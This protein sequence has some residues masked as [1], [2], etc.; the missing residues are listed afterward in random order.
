[1]RAIV[2]IALVLIFIPGAFA[3][4]DGRLRIL[5]VTGGHGYKTSFYTVFQDSELWTWDHEYPASHA[6]R[7]NLVQHYDVIVL[8]DASREDIGPKAQQNLRRFVE[9]GKGVVV[10][11]HAL[12]NKGYGEWW[13]KHTLGALYLREPYAGKPTSNFSHDENVTVRA[14]VDHPITKGLSQ[15]DLIDETYKGV[16][17]SPDIRVLMEG[18][19]P[20]GDKPVVW[21]GPGKLNRTVCI[22]LGHDQHAFYS[23]GFRTL[24]SQ[25]IQWVAEGPK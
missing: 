22:Q 3:A 4:E 7:R 8:Y 18:D 12:L 24:V 25:A 5:V 14:V 6:Y 1:M 17:F 15:I 10:L 11:H 21:V 19:N 13:W 9:S 20:K 2:L 23:A 16:W